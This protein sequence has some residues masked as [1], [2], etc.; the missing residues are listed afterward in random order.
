ME[1]DLFILQ[2]QRKY[3]ARS[4]EFQFIVYKDFY[5]SREIG[6]SKA[7]PFL[8]C[9]S[10]VLMLLL[11]NSFHSFVFT[12]QPP[13]SKILGSL[14]KGINSCLSLPTVLFPPTPPT[15]LCYAPLIRNLA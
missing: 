2:L 1:L 11:E 9:Q 12:G 7:V 4:N 13:H 15:T 3:Q 6:F 5:G 14:E 10:T 8:G